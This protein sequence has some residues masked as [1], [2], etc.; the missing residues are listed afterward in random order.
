MTSN[1][2]ATRIHR[3]RIAAVVATLALVGGA[4]A[5][6]TQATAA[7]KADA[8]QQGLDGLLRTD[9]WPAALAAVQD[10]S[11]RIRDYT[12]GV[13][14]LRTGAPVPRDGYVRIGSNTKTFTAVV[15]LQLVAE[16]K[17]RL[18]EPV[19]T[20]LPGLLRGDGIDGRDIT[21]RQLLQHTSGLPNY[22][23]FLADGLL[24]HLRD[25]AEPRDLLDR[26]LT[27]KAEFA[28]GTKWSYSN[29]NYLVA[30]LL[31]ERLTH[32][33]VIEEIT[34]RVI[35][36]AGLKH[37]YFPNVG[38]VTVRNPHPHGYHHDDV[39]KPLVDVTELDPSW[40]WAAGQLIATPSDIDRFFTAL[41]G[42]KLLP[43]AQLAEMRRTV[44]AD[45]LGPGVRYGL[46]LTSTPLSCGG[47]AWGHG[48][49][50]TG[51]STVNG[52][53]DDGRAAAIATTELPRELA[54]VERLNAVVDTAIC[55]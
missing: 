42:G 29:T 31:I 44:P 8:V 12:A 35:D 43:K 30:G 39:S 33:P 53:T 25:Y 16:G 49:D 22:T 2:T 46:G 19:E 5:I 26:A 51:Y 18:D 23:S 50:I 1:G 11:G 4:T 21:V 7:P 54:Q 14:D 48:G 17:V 55:R 41:L 47:V 40:G 34:R 10:R 24:N 45:D 20:Y 36:R 9:H 38:D 37:T 32:R 13:G 27:R 3:R 52:A 6:G 28:P 15:V